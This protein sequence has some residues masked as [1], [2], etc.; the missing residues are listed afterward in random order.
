[1]KEHLLVL[2]VV[3]TLADVGVFGVQGYQI[4]VLNNQQAQIS[5]NAEKSSCWAH[6][7]DEAISKP[8]LSK[9][10]KARLTVRGQACRHLP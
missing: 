3:G 10:D 1:M 9:A 6:I 8:H 2:V 7:L 5:Q 4:H